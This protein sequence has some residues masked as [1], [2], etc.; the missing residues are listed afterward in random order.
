MVVALPQDAVLLRREVVEPLF[1]FRFVV[2]PA[3]SRVRS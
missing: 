1:W 3:L 2:G